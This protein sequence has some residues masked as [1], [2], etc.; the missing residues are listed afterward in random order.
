MADKM[1]VEERITLLEVGLKIASAQSQGALSLL[2]LLMPILARNMT[3]D[4]LHK[5]GDELNKM[6]Q[7]SKHE[8][9]AEIRSAMKRLGL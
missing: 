9:T 2:G 7:E 5:I 4:E 3:S 1:T 8:N 6:M